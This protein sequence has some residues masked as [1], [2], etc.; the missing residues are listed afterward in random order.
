MKLRITSAA[1]ALTIA[2]VYFTLSAVPSF[3]DNVGTVNA[4]VTVAAPCLTLSTTSID[5]GTILFATNP[6]TGPTSKFI[7]P[8]TIT[9]CGS[10]NE[11]LYVKGTDATSTSSSTKWTLNWISPCTAG[12]NNYGMRATEQWVGGGYRDLTTTAQAL[13][14]ALPDG[15]AKSYNN[16]ISSPCVGSNGAGE[17]MTMQIVYTVAF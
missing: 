2:A 7:L 3:G 16:E 1:A 12:P 5:F 8:Y 14:T 17:T 9:N 10:A 4:Q 15:T 6:P 13:P 11:T